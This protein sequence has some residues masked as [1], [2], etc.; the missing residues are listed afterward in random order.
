MEEEL[1]TKIEDGIFYVYNITPENEK[2]LKIPEN[3]I[4]L[5]IKG[6]YLDHFCIPYNIKDINIDYIGLKTLYI[7]DGVEKV[8]CSKNFLKT[9]E[10]PQSLLTLI[11]NKNLLTEIT[12]RSS[13]GNKLEYLDIR[14]NKLTELN[15]DLDNLSYFTAA[16]NKIS[17]I[18]PKIR[19]YLT[20]Q[21]LPAPDSSSSSD[22]ENWYNLLNSNSV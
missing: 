18:A 11:A 19:N 20:M 1:E 8:V 21:Y 16:M 5:H 14:S 13:S 6:Y 7:P 3:I 22:D 9:I 17:Y 15:F 10:I 2:S 12:F 4:C